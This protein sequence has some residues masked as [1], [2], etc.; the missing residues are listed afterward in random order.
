MPNEHE[1]PAASPN[2]SNRR[3]FLE[4][5]LGAGAAVWAA[6]IAVPTGIYL[7][8]AAASGP[9]KKYIELDPESQAP[10]TGRVLGEGGK[11][12]LLLRQKNGEFR[13]LSAV[14]THLGCVVHWNAEQQQIQCPCHAGTF[15]PEGAVVSGPPPRPLASYPTQLVAG[16]LRITT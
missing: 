10:G 8:P 9:T 2:E 16:K 14:C 12:V 11:P 1:P 7:W 13:A 15:T 3:D 5:A 6:G 4:R